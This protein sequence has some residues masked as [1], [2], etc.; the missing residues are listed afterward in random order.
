MHNVQSPRPLYTG[1]YT[2]VTYNTTSNQNMWQVYSRSFVSRL[3][4]MRCSV[5]QTFVINIMV[6]TV[7]LL[8]ANKYHKVVNFTATFNVLFCEPDFCYQH[9]VFQLHFL[10]TNECHKEANKKWSMSQ[11]RSRYRQ[12]FAFSHCHCACEKLVTRIKNSIKGGQYTRFHHSY[13]RSTIITLNLSYQ[14]WF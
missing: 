3:T 11:F 9:S 5:K 2:M 10:F 1:T 7:L 8:F 14:S 6:F 12:S 13:A 4:L